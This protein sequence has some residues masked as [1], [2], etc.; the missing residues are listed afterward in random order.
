[1]AEATAHFSGGCLCKAV[2]YQVS[3]PPV[4]VR[5]CWCRTCQY[6]GAGSATV[7]AIF[8]TAALTVEG[9]LGEYSTDGRQWQRHDPAILPAV[10][11]A[12][13]GE[14]LGAP[15]IHWYSRRDTRRPGFRAAGRHHLDLCCPPLGCD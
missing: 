11:H 8:P 15:G 12:G 4:T 1:M 6:L 13:A 5:A 9:A 7:N 2:R 3:S 10:R 14:L